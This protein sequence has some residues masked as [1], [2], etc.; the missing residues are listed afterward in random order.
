MHDKRCS[1]CNRNLNGGETVFEVERSRY[2]CNF[3]CVPVGQ[4]SLL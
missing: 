4:L 3:C 1:G 2:Y